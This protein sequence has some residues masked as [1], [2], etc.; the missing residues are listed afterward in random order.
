[1][2]RRRWGTAAA[3]S[4]Q[5]LKAGPLRQAVETTTGVAAP[6]RTE[7]TVSSLGR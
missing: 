3:P 5:S 1:M 7:T 4:G 6:K 2:V